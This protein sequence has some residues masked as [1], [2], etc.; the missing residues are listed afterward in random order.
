MC[1]NK[2][3]N[4]SLRARRALLGQAAVETQS[5]SLSLAQ[6]TISS[7]KCWRQGLS[8]LQFYLWPPPGC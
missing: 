5:L 4:R 3:H 1:V 2:N 7:S 6:T 8:F